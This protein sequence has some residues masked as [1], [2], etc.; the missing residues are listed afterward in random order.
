MLRKS[1]SVVVLI[2]Q[3]YAYSPG[4]ATLH[5]PHGH[6]HLSGIIQ[7]GGHLRVIRRWGDSC[8]SNYDTMRRTHTKPPPTLEVSNYRS[9]CDSNMK[10]QIQLTI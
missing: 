2:D 5:L 7:T 4:T 10:Q 8:T 6:H 1:L 3:V 9:R